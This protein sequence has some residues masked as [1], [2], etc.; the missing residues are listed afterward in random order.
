MW[1]TGAKLSMKAHAG[2]SKGGNNEASRLESNK[3]GVSSKKKGYKL[4]KDRRIMENVAYSVPCNNDGF[5]SK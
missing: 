1:V 4:E 2:L 5:P 3:Q